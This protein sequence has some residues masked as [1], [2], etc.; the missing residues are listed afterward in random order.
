MLAQRLE[1]ESRESR[2]CFGGHTVVILR[3]YTFNC[4]ACGKEYANRLSSVLLGTGKRKCK[5]CGAVFLD[6]CKEWPE[7]S[8]SQKFQYFFPTVVLGF[9]TGGVLVGAFA[10][11]TFGDDLRMGFFMSGV[12]LS[13]FAMPWVPYFL[14]QRRHIPES[15]ERYERHKVFGDT[16]EFVL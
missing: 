4:P 1:L 7:L 10:I 2:Q 13:M 9:V 11:F 3:Y 14:L 12:V 8:G 5:K 16:D 15:R 6:G